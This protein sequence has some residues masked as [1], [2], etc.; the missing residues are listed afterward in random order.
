MTLRRDAL[1][2][3]ANWIDRVAAIARDGD[4]LV[5]TVGRLE[6]EPNASNVVPGRVRLSLDVRHADDATRVRAVETMFATG[7]HLAGS[8][9]F[10]A[11]RDAE[12]ATVPMDAGLVERLAA[13]C[14]RVGVRAH[15]MPS[16]AG[17]DAAVLAPLV[18]SCMLFV[19]SPGG[20]SHHPDEA[21]IPA[22]VELALAAML[23]FVEDSGRG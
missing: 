10:D 18:P 7:R 14:T 17:H 4:G 23:E 8:L 19:R 1:L 22:D 9:S 12:H 16:G 13:A 20:I 21:V 2:V 15:P 6:V 3:A 5:A 11:V